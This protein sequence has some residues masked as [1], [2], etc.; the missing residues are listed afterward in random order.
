MEDELDL[1][2]TKDRS[3]RSNISSKNKKLSSYSSK[4]S[5]RPERVKTSIPKMQKSQTSKA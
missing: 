2:P 4:Q 3:A 5:F 1:I